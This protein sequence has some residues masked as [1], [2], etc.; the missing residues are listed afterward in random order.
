MAI[1]VP[2]LAP[3][4]GFVRCTIVSLFIDKICYFQYIILKNSKN[5]KIV[6]S[7]LGFKLIKLSLLLAHPVYVQFRHRGR[8]LAHVV[9]T[10]KY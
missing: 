9:L 7:F 3:R 4:S 6:L 1:R 10:A 8:L 2:V 5:F